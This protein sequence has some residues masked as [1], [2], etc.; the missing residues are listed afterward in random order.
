MTTGLSTPGQLIVPNDFTIPHG[1]DSDE[2]TRIL[3]PL[4]IPGKR[5]FEPLVL[6][7]FGRRGKGK[8]LAMTALARIM[9]DRYRA[10]GVDFAVV[11]NYSINFADRSDPYL[12][13][14][15]INFPP[16]AYRLLIC[17]DEVATA[18]PGR[19]SMAAIN[20]AFSNF[21]TQIRKRQIEV[22]FTTQFPQVVDQQVLMQVDLFVRCETFMGARH[23]RLFVHD[24]WGQYTGD[25]GRKPW[26][27]QAGTHDSEL[28]I[29]NTNT[30]FDAYRT[31]EVVA[32]PSSKSRDELIAQQWDLPGEAEG[33]DSND[34]AEVPRP[35][36]TMEEAISVM[37]EKFGA[38]EV[39]EFL[40]IARKFDPRIAGVPALKKLLE[41]HGYTIAMYG[42]IP[43]AEK[44][45]G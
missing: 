36:E 14:Y 41:R 31:E 15:L 26:P 39:A 1:E 6:F 30:L 34:L 38:F 40:P 18:Y 25:M 5:R 12:L 13:D 2:G 10:A 4:D 43:I 9:A 17:V 19:R 23:T 42:N 3:S 20:L 28:T 21:L 22:M 29:Y 27:P 37:H 35:P 11:S 33:D 8:T 32:A 7:F 45:P 24:W 44:G 16:W